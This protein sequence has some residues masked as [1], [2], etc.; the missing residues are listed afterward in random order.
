MIPFVTINLDRPY[1]LRFGLAAMVE[2]EQLTK[3][4]MTQ[5]DGAELGMTT[6]AQLLWVMIRREK[7]ELTFED[8]LELIDENI[9]DFNYLTEMV[10]KVFEAAFP[11]GNGDPKNAVKPKANT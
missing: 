10:T 1:N 6:I 8:T 2:F 7:K 4:K 11:A 3:I 5:L 9:E